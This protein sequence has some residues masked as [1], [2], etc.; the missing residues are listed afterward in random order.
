MF[1]GDSQTITVTVLD[2]AGD[3]F[4]LTLWTVA[5]AAVS[6]ALTINKAGTVAAPMTGVAT[7]ELDPA[8]TAS[9]TA[10]VTVFGWSIRITDGTDVHTVDTGDLIVTK[11]PDQA[12]PSTVDTCTLTGTVYLSATGQGGQ[13]V[14]WRVISDEPPVTAG[15]GWASGV[16]TVTYTD[17]SGVWSLTLPQGLTVWLEIPAAGV[18]HYLTVPAASTRSE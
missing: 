12:G 2:N 1:A 13:L 3:P 6:G 18:D 16:P 7:V 10:D 5:F 9:L 4:D 11:V 8:D 14:R 17:A 15:D